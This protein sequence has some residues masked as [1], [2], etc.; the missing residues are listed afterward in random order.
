MI[1]VIAGE[2]GIGE[3]RN[4]SAQRGSQEGWLLPLPPQIRLCGSG[5]LGH[6]QTNE[7]AVDRCFHDR[8]SRLNTYAVRPG[9]AQVIGLVRSQVRCPDIHDVDLG[10]SGRPRGTDPL[11]APFALISAEC[12]DPLLLNRPSLRFR[13]ADRVGGRH[14]HRSGGS[15]VGPRA[16]LQCRLA[17]LAAGAVSMALGE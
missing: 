11:P 8:E 14:R 10:L 17:G 9:Q 3:R 13:I 7:L 2:T 15:H 5:E 4:S 1:S 12:G 16:C 6:T